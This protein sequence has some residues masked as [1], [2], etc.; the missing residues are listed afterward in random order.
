L[1]LSNAQEEMMRFLQTAA[2]QAFA[3]IGDLFW[4]NG[5]AG[6]I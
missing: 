1:A 5:A 4:G 6:E 2:H 3:I